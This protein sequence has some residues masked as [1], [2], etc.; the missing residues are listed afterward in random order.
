[1]KKFLK[2][3]LVIVV[4]VPLLALGW[5]FYSTPRNLAV[6]TPEAMAMLESDTAVHVEYDDW[7]VMRP[8]TRKPKAGLILYIGANC[9]LPGYLPALRDVAAAGYLV[10]IPSM[11]FDFAIFSP[12]K[13]DEVMAAYPDIEQWVLAGHSMGGAMAGRY[14]YLY[15]E[16]LAGLIFLDAYPPDSNSLAESTL[17][18]WH[19]HRAKPD[20]TPSQMFVDRRDLFPPDS[21]WVGVP[22][23]QH[24][25]FG[26]FD[27]GAYVEEWPAGIERK[28]QHMMV[29][30]TTL[31]AMDQMTGHYSAP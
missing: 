27:G 1:M 12:N 26:A 9:D 4:L 22:G 24:M 29:R 7:L 25:Y 31:S 2:I 14:A 15:P 13:A 3:L 10:V 23:G 8:A 20:G 5:L 19:I 30:F 21:V 28:D 11:P 17:P 16:K 6:A 18:V